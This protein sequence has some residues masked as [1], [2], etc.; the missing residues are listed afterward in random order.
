M[1]KIITLLVFP[2]FG[3]SQIKLD[4]TINLLDNKVEIHVPKTLSIMS[5][6]MWTLKYHT[7]T[8]PELV[9]TDENAEINFLVNTTQ[10]PST[11]N[12]LA[13]YKDFRI[14]NLK[15]SRTDII[16]LGDGLKIVNG[17]KLGFFKFL[18]QAIDQKVF[19]YYFFTIVNGKILFF[20]F[21]CIEKLQSTWE[22]TADDILNSLQVKL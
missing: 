15:K 1:M 6:E 14:A 10:Q 22:K 4:K 12:Q 5:D 17:K 21:N 9:L 11:E 19:N 8:R 20:T 13:A 18:S 3:F 16:M 7:Q 2:I